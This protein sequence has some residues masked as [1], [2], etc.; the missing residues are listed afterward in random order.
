[1]L[2]EASITLTKSHGM[3]IYI[4]IC[5]YVSIPIYVCKYTYIYGF[6]MLD[7]YDAGRGVHN[8][9][10]IPWYETVYVKFICCETPIL[11]YTYCG[12]VLL[13][14]YHSFVVC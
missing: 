9:N 10:E 3:D 4:Y 2:R 5:I 7:S 11:G 13:Y 6:E 14:L 8:A 12:A 1:M